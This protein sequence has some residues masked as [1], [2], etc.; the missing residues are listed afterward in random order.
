MDFEIRSEIR[1]RLREL[2]T[3]IEKSFQPLEER[4]DAV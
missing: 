3:F 4:A 2:D 1:D